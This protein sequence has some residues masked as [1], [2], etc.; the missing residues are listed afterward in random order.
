QRPLR[1]LLSDRIQSDA[2]LPHARRAGG[3]QASVDLRDGPCA[4]QRAAHEGDPRLARSLLWP[5]GA[6]GFPDGREHF[7]ALQIAARHGRRRGY[8]LFTSG[9]NSGKYSASFDSA[10][11]PKRM[12]QASRSPAARRISSRRTTSAILDRRRR[13]SSSLTTISRRAASS[14]S[15]RMYSL[16]SMMSSAMRGSRRMASS[17]PNASGP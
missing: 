11:S 15:Q 17:S 12:R 10:S 5:R 4:A 3:G 14:S 1:L 6:A 13:K 2:I 7:A 16:V 9:R 8:A